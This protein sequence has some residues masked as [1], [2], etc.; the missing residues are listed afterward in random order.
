MKW[1]HRRALLALLLS[2]LAVAL[3]PPGA[4]AAPPLEV[5]GNLPGL[6]EAALSQSGE[7]IALIA[8]VADTRRLIV[9]DKDFKPLLNT[10]LGEMKVRG[11]YWA[12]DGTVLIYK[13]DTRG[14]SVLD[15]TTGKAEL[16]SMLVVP[17]E[18]ARAWSV[19]AGEKSITGGIH[20]FHGVRQRNGRFFGYFGGI[21]LDRGFDTTGKRLESTEPVLY[22]VDLQ[23]QAIKKLAPRLEGVGYRDWIVGSDGAVNATL[24]YFS[25]SG[26][27]AIRNRAGDRIA[28]GTHLQGAIGLVGLGSSPDTLIYSV[29]N[30]QG[31]NVD[32]YELP[33]AGGEA[34]AALAD[35]AVGDIIVDE[36][37]QQIMGLQLE[38]DRPAYKLFNAREQ[39]VID[40]AV[41]AF[42]GV[43]VH[44][45]D[46]NEA[47]DKLLVMTEGVGDP[48][49]WWSVD[50]K[51]GKA[52]DL[53]VAYPMRSQDVAPMRMVQYKAADGLEIAAVLTLPPGLPGKNL[54]VVI[55]PHGGPRAR[56]YP[57]FDWWA[58]AFASRGYA[59]LQ[60]NFRGSSG[61]GAEFLSAGN[62]EWG[63]RMQSDIS[64]GL[65]FLV[66][67][68]IVDAKRA[69]I[70]G[71]S[72]GGY[73]ALA[74]VT[75]QKGLYRCAVSVAGVSDLDK[76]V[77]TDLE[78]QA[79]DASLRRALK[80]LVGSGKDLRAVSP[81]RHAAA[82]DAP[83]LLIH[84]KD[85]IVVLHDQ[86]AAMANAL[87]KADNAVEFVT[88][89]GEDHWLSTSK[90]RLA[91]LKA[92]IIF[93]E[94]HNPAGV[95]AP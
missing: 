45:Q 35:V 61:Y 77:E 23:N 57:G 49:T 71:A 48:Q 36:K 25:K 78:E 50:I 92:A 16:F 14:L 53:G 41:R 11:L 2:A 80:E 5:Y 30:L 26:D 95:T 89:P 9:L 88:L 33:L 10:P 54:P 20:G 27:W 43:S 85:D 76:M 84:G 66:Q 21:T 39:R 12:G 55:L 34:K 52:R 51:T 87:R 13:S 72:Y 46:W 59:V 29:S 81:L 22:E 83:I 40:G 8:A 58:Q 63:R 31:G 56:D 37:S 79:G 19:F 6:E 38:A 64:D 62:G 90:T 94:K 42:P 15:F 65:A 75:L 47:F 4:S 69:C 68:G 18:G 24:D 28:S 17:L 1:M 32:W 60:P 73:A 3:V 86:S 82:A 67:E 7:R 44:L 70:M 93:V 91:M 74:G